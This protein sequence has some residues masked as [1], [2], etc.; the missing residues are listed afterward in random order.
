M[1]RLKNQ[2]FVCLD[3]EA[4]GL[5]PEKD[6]IIEVAVVQFDGEQTYQKFESLVNPKCLIPKAS[7]EIHHI[8]DQMIQDKPTIDKLLGEILDIIGD[9]IL[10]GHNILYDITLIQN[11]AK[12]YGIP[13]AIEKN[14]YIDTLRMARAYGESPKNSLEDLRQHF[15]IEL[16]GAHRAMNDVVVNIAV[17]RRLCQNYYSLKDIFDLLA[18]PVKLRLMPLGKHKGRPFSEVPLNY[19]YWAANKEFDQDLLFSIRSEISKR[20]S[21]ELFNQAGNPFQNL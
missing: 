13:C 7:T 8:T 20:K 18:K 10:I 9:H 5:D 3:C 4:T 1:T 16:E 12:Q 21:G 6:Q 11:A 15:N 17:F 2:K 14:R 19:L